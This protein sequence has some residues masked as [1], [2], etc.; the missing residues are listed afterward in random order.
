M[1]RKVDEHKLNHLPSSFIL[2]YGDKNHRIFLTH[3]EFRCFK[4]HNSG[5]KADKCPSITDD[6]IEYGEDSLPTQSTAVM[7]DFKTPSLIELKDFPAISKAAPEIIPAKTVNRTL[8]PN[9]KDEIQINGDTIKRPPPASSTNSNKSSTTLQPKKKKPQQTNIN[10][11]DNREVDLSKTSESE[12]EIT[13]INSPLSL[14][15]LFLL[16]NNP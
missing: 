15:P 2:R 3:D 8:Q 16:E 10:S 1:Y 9:S 6:M 4:C 11:R 5:H 13:Q 12:E 14:H 7:H